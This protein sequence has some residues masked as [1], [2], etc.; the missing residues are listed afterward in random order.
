METKLV[1]SEEE[2][3]S[4]KNG[5]VMDLD[6][7]VEYLVQFNK[8]T[9]SKSKQ[10]KKIA[11]KFKGADPVLQRK[12]IL[13]FMKDELY[14]IFQREFLDKFYK[15]KEYEVLDKDIIATYIFG[16]FLEGHSTTT[17]IDIPTQFKLITVE[18]TNRIYSELEKKNRES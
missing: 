18:L 16:T 6:L 2:A 1:A 17:K 12:K 13:K 3:N 4:Q 5:I 9:V 7:G 14:P 8:K 15:N 10:F 11:K